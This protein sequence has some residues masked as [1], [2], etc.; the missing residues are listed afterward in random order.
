MN[1]TIKIIILSG[2]LIAS[3]CVFGIAVQLGIQHG[4]STLA[5]AIQ[6]GIIAHG[7]SIKAGL[8]YPLFIKEQ[9]K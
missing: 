9:F 5:I 1:D 8:E 6:A 7:E 2:S 4:C 3:A